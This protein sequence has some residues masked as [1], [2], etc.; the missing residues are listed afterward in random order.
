MKKKCTAR[1]WYLEKS[2]WHTGCPRYT[3]NRKTPFSISYPSLL[4]SWNLE[5]HDGL[6]CGCYKGG[7][8]LVRHV[9]TSGCL[10]WRF[11]LGWKFLDGSMD[12][13]RKTYLM[14]RHGKSLVDAESGDPVGK[15]PRRP[16][17]VWAA[18]LLQNGSNRPNP[19]GGQHIIGECH[20]REMLIISAFPGKYPAYQPY[21]SGWRSCGQLGP[22]CILRYE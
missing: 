17:R 22:F 8:F 7:I 9:V 15:L 10:G 1:Y 3:P 21:F 18:P 14:P 19:A 12:G 20:R 4:K 2:F 13:R 5:W 16:R 6:F 11:S